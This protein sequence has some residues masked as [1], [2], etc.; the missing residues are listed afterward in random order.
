MEKIEKILDIFTNNYVY[1]DVAVKI[2]QNIR[3][4]KI[5]GGYDNLDEKQLISKLRQ[6][7]KDLIKK[8]QFD[9][10]L[11]KIDN[12]KNIF[13]DKL[14]VED[15]IGYIKFERFPPEEL[16]KFKLRDAMETFSKACRGIIIDL[17]NNTGGDYETMA[18]FMSYFI[19]YRTP[20]ISISSKNKTK[21]IYTLS[22]DHLQKKMERNVPVYYNTSII[23]LVNEKTASVAEAFV[24]NIKNMNRGLVMGINTAGTATIGGIY[25]AYNV[26]LYIATQ[27]LVSLITGVNWE[28][29]GI[30][31]DI[32]CENKY[33]IENAYNQMKILN[34]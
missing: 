8:R 11:D 9:I 29:T 25:N 23:V 22:N 12:N 2:N 15:R 3:Y 10:S 34:N 26:N 28:I 4:N 1:R 20:L 33:V 6:D 5:K 19:N 31:P 17:Q 13:F 18:L 16:Y 32:K 27:S 21:N 7:F 30:E 14:S 24:Y